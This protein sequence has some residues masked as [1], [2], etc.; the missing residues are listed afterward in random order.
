MELKE[1]FRKI[2]WIPLVVGILAIGLGIYFVVNFGSAFE[3]LIIFISVFM[4]V[5][6]VL[7]IIA[8]IG[9]RAENKT[10]IF[11]LILFAITV[12]AG[13]LLLVYPAAAAL[14]I[15]IFCGIGF[16]SEGISLISNAFVF[17]RLGDGPWVFSLILGILIVL[18]SFSIIGRPFFSFIFVSVLVAVNVL[19]FGINCII[20]SFQM[21]KNS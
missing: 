18:A 12:I 20:A 17:K 9:S 1:T 5:S 8:A 21:K 16:L 14:M 4:I 11:N 2:W 19:S 10:W 7:G 13:V 15:H 6:G 3:A